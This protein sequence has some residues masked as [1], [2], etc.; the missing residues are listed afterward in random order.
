MELSWPHLRVA[1]SYS[2]QYGTA[3]PQRIIERAAADGHRVI[4]LTDRDGVYGAVQWVQAAQQAGLT[5]V[6]GV[7]LAV[8]PVHA[9]AIHTRARRT[10]ARGGAWVAQGDA[11][12]VFLARGRAGWASLSRLIS[13]A[14]ANADRYGL[15]ILEASD[16]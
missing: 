7:D 8:V 6:V 4:A 5:P 3:T 12:V 10:P 2:L 15:P 11:R 13:A 16:L 14:H 9:P 1:S